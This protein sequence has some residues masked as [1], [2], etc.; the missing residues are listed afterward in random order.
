MKYLKLIEVC[1][2]VQGYAFKSS[3]F[4]SSGANVVKITDINPPNVDTTNCSK[5]NI[6]KYDLKKLSKFEVHRGD[7]VIAMTGATVGKLGMVRNGSAY[8]NQRT[9]KFCAKTVN[10]TYLYYVLSSNKFY[11][12]IINNIDSNSAQPN[13]SANS[14]GRYQFKCHEPAEQQHIVNSIICEVNY[15]C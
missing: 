11:E 15:A 5:I 13:I 9:A 2:I 6:E 1:D 14:I 12:F 8:L 3:D 7:F 10:Q 4:C